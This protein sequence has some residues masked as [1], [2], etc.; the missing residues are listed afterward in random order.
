MVIAFSFVPPALKIT[1]I[2]CNVAFPIVQFVAFLWSSLSAK[3]GMYNIKLPENLS[4]CDSFA[5]QCNSWP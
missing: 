3:A 4:W 2:M 5:Q 1:S